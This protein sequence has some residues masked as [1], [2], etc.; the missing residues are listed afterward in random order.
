MTLA[1]NVHEAEAIPAAARD[2]IDALMKSGDL[3][4]YTAPQDA[5]VALLETEFAELL[6]TK[7][8]LAAY[9]A[10]W[11]TVPTL[12]IWSSANLAVASQL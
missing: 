10:M 7:Y 4:R 1:P 2:A 3:F 11:G 5:P 9:S 12:R 6:G 8:A